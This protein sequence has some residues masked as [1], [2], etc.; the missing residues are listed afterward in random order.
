MFHFEIDTFK[1]LSSKIVDSTE[2]KLYDGKQFIARFSNGYGV[3]VVKHGLS[4]GLELAVIKFHGPSIKDFKL[5]YT[6]PI[7]DDV[8]GNLEES[9]IYKIAE[10]V[11]ALPSV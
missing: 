4:Y 9:D 10:Q 5:D 6:T 11:S 2:T 3:S 8:L 7:T 1:S